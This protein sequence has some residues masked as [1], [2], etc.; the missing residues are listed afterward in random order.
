M[1][2]LRLGTFVSVAIGIS[3][4]T[5]TCGCVGDELDNIHV[6]AMWLQ[7]SGTRRGYRDSSKYTCTLFNP[8]HVLRS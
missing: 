2:G 1:P 6:W 7:F 5:W 8:L 3:L 4:P